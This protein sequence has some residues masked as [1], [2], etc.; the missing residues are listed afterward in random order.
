[1]SYICKNT[2]WKV[3]NVQMDLEGIYL[4]HFLASPERLNMNNLIFTSS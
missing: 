3:V 1:M 4:N 2:V